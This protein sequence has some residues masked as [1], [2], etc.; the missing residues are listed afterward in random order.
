MKRKDMQRHIE[1]C[2]TNVYKT[3]FDQEMGTLPK[4]QQVM[5]IDDE[6]STQIIF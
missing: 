4:K 2:T 6:F 3:L 1:V 5:N